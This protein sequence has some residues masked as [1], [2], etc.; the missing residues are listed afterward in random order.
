MKKRFITGELITLL[1]SANLA[2]HRSFTFVQSQVWLST[3]NITPAT[4]AR[5]SYSVIAS[6]AY[7]RW[8]A[9]PWLTINNYDFRADMVDRSVATDAR[10]RARA[11]DRE[12]R[13]LFKERIHGMEISCG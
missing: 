3:L 8:G 7:T 9:G 11:A 5:I 10:V 12:R 2:K 6:G 13:K 1:Q 4:D